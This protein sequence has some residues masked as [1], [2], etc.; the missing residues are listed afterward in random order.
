MKWAQSSSLFLICIMSLLL[1][2]RMLFDT[3]LLFDLKITWPVPRA[4]AAQVL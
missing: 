4:S 2:V 1:E 3:L